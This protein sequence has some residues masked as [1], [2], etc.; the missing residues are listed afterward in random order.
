MGIRPFVPSWL[1]VD[2][3]PAMDIQRAVDIEPV[4]DVSRD[5]WWAAGFLPGDTSCYYYAVDV[6]PAAAA[7]FAGAA[8]STTA[9]WTAVI[10][11]S[12]VIIQPE[13]IHNVSWP[14][15]YEAP[16][17]PSGRTVCF[18]VIMLKPSPPRTTALWTYPL[19]P[20]GTACT[21]QL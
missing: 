16:P 9:V 13:V 12:V 7:W 6:S 5:P 11:W 2:V 21:R 3:E 1:A 18:G 17:P 15:R 20:L 4:L 10:A 19:P 14:N 8:W